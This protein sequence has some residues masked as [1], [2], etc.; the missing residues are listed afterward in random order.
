MQE[1]ARPAEV[2]KIELYRLTN[3]ELFKRANVDVRGD[4]T[5]FHFYPKNTENTLAQLE[6]GYRGRPA[7]QIRRTYFGV[8][9]EG[10][11]YRFTVTRQIYHQ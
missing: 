1:K 5:I 3:A 2:N 9:S 11:G 7:K 8:E 10:T 6:L 4:T